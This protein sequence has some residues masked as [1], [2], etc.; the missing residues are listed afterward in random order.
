MSYAPLW[1]KSN[2][3]FLEGASHAEELVEEAHRVGLGS[4]AITDRDGV[5][6]MVRAHTKARELGVH[7]V[8]G[9]Q[10][11]IAP[12][13]SL[14]APSPV[15][16]PRVGLHHDDAPVGRGPGWGADT[17]ALSPN[18]SLGRR[19]RTKR[20]KPRQVALEM[21][22]GSP[23][24]SLAS[25]LVLL[26]IDRAG[27][28]NLM[29]LLTS[30]RRRCDKGES[31]ASWREVCER[32]AGVIALWGGEGSLLAGEAEPPPAVITDLKNAFGD[33]LYALLARHR[34]ADDV[35]R[36]ARLRARA[37]DAR[38]PLVAST[39]VLYHSRA[40]RSLQDILTCIRHGVTLATA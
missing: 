9:A 6:G 26:A 4:I 28:A 12:P 25:T 31:L 38:I 3:S 37:A 39:E 22:D 14:L 18:V 2:F 11:S 27:W 10:V 29:R 34:R 16:A 40:R 21:T 5:Y 23:G 33:R 32:A 8:C 15:T 24:S 7:L 36:E 17:D 35:P 1:C 13:G 30:A 19:G 20:A